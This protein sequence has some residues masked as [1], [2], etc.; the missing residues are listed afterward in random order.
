MMRYVGCAII[1]LAYFI[2]PLDALPDPVYLDDLAVNVILF[3][4]A[5]KGGK[6]TK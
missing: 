6:G 3:I 1:G 5:A 4:I 2:W